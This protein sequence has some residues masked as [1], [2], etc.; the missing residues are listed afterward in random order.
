MNRLAPYAAFFMRLAVGGV[1]LQHGAT[2]FHSG[3]PAV[4][5]FLHGMGF[6]FANIG[7]AILIVVETIG[8]A[9]VLLGIFTRLWAACMAVEMAVAIFAVKVPRGGNIELEALLLASAITLVALGDGPL[10]VAIGLK[11][12][13]S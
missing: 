2:K 10:S 3:L 7:A 13:D 11:R 5:G 1:F 6:P 4:A 8:A 12:G 9:C